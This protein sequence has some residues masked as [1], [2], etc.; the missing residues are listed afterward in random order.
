MDKNLLKISNTLTIPWHEIVIQFI[1]AQGAGGQHVN[2]TSTAVHLFFDIKASKSL[3]PW[4]KSKLLALNDHRISKSGKIIIKS[5]STRS[6]DANKDAA[7]KQFIE[8]IRQ[9]NKIEKRRIATKPTFG[10]KLRRLDK[11]N[12]QGMQKSLRKRIDY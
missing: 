3:P 1:R 4:L 11:K 10:S 12:K 7:L 2:K 8:L 5:Q 6:Q 9:V